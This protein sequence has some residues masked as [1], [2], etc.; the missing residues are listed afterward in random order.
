VT[1][2][3]ETTKRIALGARPFRLAEL[4]SLIAAAFKL[5]LEA[6][7]V[8]NIED[9]E[10]IWIDSLFPLPTLLIQH[11]ITSSFLPTCP[12][13][14]FIWPALAIS[15]F[16]S[17]ESYREMRFLYNWKGKIPGKLIY[18]FIGAIVNGFWKLPLMDLPAL[19]KQ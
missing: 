3:R 17:R 1:D 10:D 5:P 12:S 16:I 11:L 18:T 8:I 4:R 14:Y 19:L 2:G 7:L 15:L 6:Q 13:P 9:G